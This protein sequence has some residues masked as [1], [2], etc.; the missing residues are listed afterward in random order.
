MWHWEQGRIEYFQYD[1]LR[2][3]AQFIVENKWESRDSMRIREVTGLDFPPRRYSPWRNYFRV[4]KLGFLAIEQHEV[5]VP[6]R[7]AEILS[8]VGETTCDEYMHFLACVSSD[9]SPALSGWSGHSERDNQARYPLCFALKYMLAKAAE[10]K[11]SQTSYAELINAYKFSNFRGGESDTA[12]VNLINS[13]SKFKNITS[14]DSVRQARESIKIISQI[15]YLHSSQREI[16]VDIP[17]EKCWEMFQSI[18]P[19]PGPS[20]QDADAEIQRLASKFCSDDGFRLPS[21]LA[22]TPLEIFYSGFRHGTKV[23]QNHLRSETQHTLRRKYYK[24]NPSPVC[25]V[26]HLDTHCRHKWA[27][28]TLHIH[29]ILPLSSGIRVNSRKGTTHGYLVAICPTC[30]SGVHQYY[31]DYLKKKGRKDFINETES[32]QVYG[33][34]KSLIRPRS[35]YRGK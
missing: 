8:Q 33:K 21:S 35:C 1:V 19:L 20:K 11:D 10:T 27:D 4:A 6:T 29:H 9:P 22:L 23:E 26:C 18:S 30:H 14:T 28:R 34:F 25:D 32:Q 15:S 5:A 17:Q 2:T 7:V 24:E 31:D 12:F 3:L 13:Q 16:T